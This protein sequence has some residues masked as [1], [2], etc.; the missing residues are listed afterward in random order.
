MT[1]YIVGLHHPNID[2]NVIVELYADKTDPTSSI[3]A[4]VGELKRLAYW[5]YGER[6][7]FATGTRKQAI[8]IGGVPQW[9]PIVAEEQEQNQ[10]P[11]VKRPNIDDSDPNNPIFR[12]VV[13]NHEF[14]FSIKYVPK[15]HQQKLAS[16]IAGDLHEA[17]AY[18]RKEA[19]TE[20]QTAIRNALML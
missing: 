11:P 2:D 1:H 6:W 18:G 9:K 15:E 10:N 4:R 17:Y 7:N 14:S 8:E 3:V 20:I 16:I 12:T 5:N 13:A 19:R